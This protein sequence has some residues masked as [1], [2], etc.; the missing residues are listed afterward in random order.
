MGGC[1]SVTIGGGW[2]VVW[3]THFL[4][5]LFK[6]LLEVRGGRKGQR[7]IECV[8]L[9]QLVLLAIGDGLFVV[10][11]CSTIHK[12]AQNQYWDGGRRQRWLFT[13]LSNHQ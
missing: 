3:F 11:L 9:F 12:N 7:K 13:L 2:F 8:L 1:C 6:T 4:T 5:I 10:S